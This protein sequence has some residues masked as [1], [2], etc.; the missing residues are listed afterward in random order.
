MHK[1]FPIRTRIEEGRQE[2]ERF[3][4]REETLL[5][6][7]DTMIEDIQ[8]TLKEKLGEIKSLQEVIRVTTIGRQALIQVK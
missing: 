6:Q 2:R 1:G 4:R 5:Q 8:N 3:K 7:K